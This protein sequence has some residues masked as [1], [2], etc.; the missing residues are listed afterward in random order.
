MFSAEKYIQRAGEAER[1]A[2]RLAVLS[3]AIREADASSAHSWRF[4]F[5]FEAI[6][7]SIFYDDAF[8]AILSF[9]E[10]LLPAVL[11]YFWKGE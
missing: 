11:F 3:E 2:A 6:K 5:R 1:G 7:E 10:L 9:P 8:K 4:Y